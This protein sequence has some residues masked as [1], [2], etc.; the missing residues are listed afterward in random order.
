MAYKYKGFW[1]RKIKGRGGRKRRRP[2]NKIIF[3]GFES[4]TIIKLDGEY[5]ISSDHWK[6]KEVEKMVNI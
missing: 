3:D 2:K 5:Y 1:Y 4:G 6:K